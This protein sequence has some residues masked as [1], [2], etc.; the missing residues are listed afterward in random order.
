MKTTF[1]KLVST[2]LCLVFCS[3]L[4]AAAQEGESASQQ[5][6]GVLFSYNSSRL[7]ASSRPILDEF[8]NM[9]KQN[10]DMKVEIA[11]HTDDNNRTNTPQLN[12]K[13]S[14]QRANT[15]KQYLVARGIA[16]K[17]LTATGYGATQP[18]ADNATVGGMAQN[19]RVELRIQ[20]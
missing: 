13:L 3:I 8:A 12:D 7:Q 11:G 15:V 5:E 18:V 4:P 16:A 19:R 20:Q 2:L 14:Q 17:R 10:P 6:D 9:L 1:T